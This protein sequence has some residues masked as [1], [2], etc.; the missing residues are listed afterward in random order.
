MPVGAKTERNV[1]K[2]LHFAVGATERHFERQ[3]RPLKQGAWLSDEP[4]DD[5]FE[6]SSGWRE[7]REKLVLDAHPDLSREHGRQH[8]QATSLRRNSK[9]SQA[10]L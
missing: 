5:M 8:D 7:R 3:P 1:R 2:E 6:R 4:V 9:N 10:R